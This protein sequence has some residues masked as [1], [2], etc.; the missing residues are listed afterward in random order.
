M[1]NHH[2]DHRDPRGDRANGARRSGQF[3]NLGIQPAFAASNRI[4][5]HQSTARGTVKNRHSGGVGSFCGFTVTGFDG[6][7]DLLDSGAVA[8]TVCTVTLPASFRL[9]GALARLRRVCQI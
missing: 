2:G 5:R 9:T 1:A 3:L 6:G 8:G 4:F 7:G